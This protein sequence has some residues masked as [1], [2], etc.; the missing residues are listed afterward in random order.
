V[1]DVGVDSTG[2]GDLV[3]GDG[4]V[5]EV[6]A[7]RNCSARACSVCGLAREKSTGVVAR[8]RWGSGA[9]RE[10]VGWFI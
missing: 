2:D 8:S 7:A 5:K 6:A 10:G 9:E 3:G 4:E 1:V